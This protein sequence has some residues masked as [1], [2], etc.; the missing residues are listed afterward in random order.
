M[1]IDLAVKFPATW[2]YVG[3]SIDEMAVS[4]HYSLPQDE[5]RCPHV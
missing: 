4:R 2:L 5:F 3:R 1:P